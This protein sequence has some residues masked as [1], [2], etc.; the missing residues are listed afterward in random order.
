MTDEQLKRPRVDNHRSPSRS[1]SPA[2]LEDAHRPN[3]NGS[4]LRNG[5]ASGSAHTQVLVE[6]EP[7]ADEV[8]EEDRQLNMQAYV[9][10]KEARA[11]QSRAIVCR[12]FLEGMQ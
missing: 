12:V 6:E 4:D 8:D 1:A 3:G 11:T 9:A 10:L 7:L 2:P 5:D